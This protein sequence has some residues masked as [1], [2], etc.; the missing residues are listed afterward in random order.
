MLTVENAQ[1][2]VTEQ[3][4]ATPTLFLHGF[5]DSG[6]LWKGIISELGGGYRCIAPDLP[7]FGRSIAPDNFDVSLAGMA[8]FIDGLV[9]QLNV[10]EPL[11]LVVID[12]GGHF[13]LA[14]ASQHPEKV[15]RLAIMNT[16]FFSDYHW[17]RVGQMIRTPILGEI[18]ALLLSNAVMKN[19]LKQGS[20]SLT[21]AQL[22]YADSLYITPALKRMMLKLYRRSDSRNFV[23]WEDQMRAMTAKVPTW[24]LWGDKDPY[25]PS[26]L[27][28]RFGAQ[29]V[30]HYPNYG[31]WL[32]LEAPAELASRLTELFA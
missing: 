32:P 5:P 2:F 14:W 10:H 24:V 16:N 22:G 6:D 15:R 1:V 30:I 25:G 20:P 29:K 23:G 11:N 31:H 4:T 27:A 26:S 28:D 7:G 9:N 12:F 18:V 19:T 21:P 3:G 8:R 13:G 17:H